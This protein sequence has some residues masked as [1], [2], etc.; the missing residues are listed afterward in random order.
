MDS[1]EVGIKLTELRKLQFQQ[2]Q[3]EHQMPSISI[4]ETHTTSNEYFETLKLQ[5]ADNESTKNV[6]WAILSVR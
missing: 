2:N 3:F 1:S 6:S 4:L 5:E